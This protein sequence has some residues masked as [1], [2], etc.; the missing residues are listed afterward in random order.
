MDMQTNPALFIVLRTIH[1]SLW[2]ASVLLAGYW[3]VRNWQRHLKIKTP[4]RPAWLTHTLSNEP[5]LF[6]SAGIALVVAIATLAVGTFDT[7]VVILSGFLSYALLS[8]LDLQRRRRDLDRLRRELPHVL[9]LIV[10]SLSAGLSL[11]AAM[12]RIAQ[13]PSLHLAQHFTVVL[14]EMRAGKPFEGAMH[15]MVDA[16]GLDELR[17]VV[18]GLVLAHNRGGSSTG[19]ILNLSRAFARAQA[20][21]AEQR[22]N[23]LPMFLL[24]PLFI[25]ILPPTLIV[26]F[27][28]IAYQLAVMF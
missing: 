6:K 5:N 10:L 14:S 3:L 4:L 1:D 26:I 12:Q 17:S 13:R 7:V 9:Q 23:Q 21:R 8:F 18:Q 22:A 15:N 11:Q 27:F 16:V 24:A 25:C 19:I 20:R 2:L 28:P